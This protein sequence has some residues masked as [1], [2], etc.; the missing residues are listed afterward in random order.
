[1]P[2]LSHSTDRAEY[3]A[4]VHPRSYLEHMGTALTYDV[5]SRYLNLWLIEKVL[6]SYR[7]EPPENTPQ[8]I[9]RIYDRIVNPP[10]L[11][12]QESEPLSDMLL[13]VCARFASVPEVRSI[14]FQ[15]YRDEIQFFVLL[16]V[17]RYDGE[18]MDRLIDIEYN[19]R[20]RY[21]SVVCEFFYPPAGSGWNRDFIHPAATCIF[22]RIEHGRLSRSSGTS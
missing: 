9:V 4:S 16:S 19:L 12:T 13:E 2:S 21:S 3:S 15:R 5:M 14:Y 7:P 1:M 22:S 10:F 18:L 8:D 11:S 6:S 20:I 17:E